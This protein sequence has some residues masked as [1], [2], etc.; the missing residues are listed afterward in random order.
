[1]STGF[2]DR[3]QDI[4]RAI[5]SE[6]VI[7][8][9]PVG[10]Q[11]LV[12]RFGL[13]FSSATVRKEMSILEQMGFLISP[14]ISSGRI[15]TDRALQFYVEGLISL[16][17]ITLTEKNKLEAFYKEAKMQL[18]KLLRTTAQLLAMK[19]KYAGF[20]LAP[21]STGSIIKRIELV[22]ILDNLILMIMVSGSGTIYQQKIQVDLSV[23][24]E[25]LYKITKYLNQHFKGYE[26]ADIQSKGLEQL[27]SGRAELGELNEV[28]VK[29]AQ[30]VVYNPPDQKIFTE[31]ES[32]LYQGIMQ[33]FPEKGESIIRLLENE[34]Y[35]RDLL[36]R[37]KEQSQVGVKFGLDV[38]GS[39]LEGVSILAKGYSIGGRSIG[40]LGVIGLSRMPY[41]KIIPTLDYGSRL[42][43]DVLN[44]LSE[45]EYESPHESLKQLTD[46][47]DLT[48]EQL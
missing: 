42:L 16:Y 12:E 30:S 3:Q 35:V 2:T 8:G 13:A 24:Q 26:L 17:E 10:S 7:S 27:K 37:T 23:T 18:E 39:F 36:N 20:V 11:V 44:E 47:V 29:V 5:V 43:S 32:S 15:P 9:E 22:S 34:E 46:A 1:M 19:S 48:K 6:F 38:E 40:A 25:E 31:G 33:Q 21:V 41:T 45:S 28:A 14:H 4:I